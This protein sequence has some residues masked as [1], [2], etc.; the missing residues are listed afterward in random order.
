MKKYND[1]DLMFFITKEWVQRDSQ[2]HIGRRL[3]ED[4]LYLVKKS[5]QSAIMMNIDVILK[6]AIVKAAG[7][8]E[9]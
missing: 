6:S 2:K 1:E 4:E 9:E 5:V 8:E 3:T 7:E